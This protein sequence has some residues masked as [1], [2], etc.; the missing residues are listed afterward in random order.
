MRMIDMDRYL[1]NRGFVVHRTYDSGLHEYTF[2]IEKDGI[3]VIKFWRYPDTFSEADKEYVQN[4]FLENIIDEWR[5]SKEKTPTPLSIKDVIFNPPATIV[6]WADGTKTVVKAQG[7]DGFDPEK[8]LAM[9]ISK[10]ALGNKGNYYNTFGKYIEKY[11]ERCELPFYLDEGFN[12]DFFSSVTKAWDDIFGKL[13]K[14][15]DSE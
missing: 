5:I 7:L 4:R 11:Y 14:K 12:M 15:S 6:L 2:Q 1:V 3:Q 9:A 10:K 13:T 8:G